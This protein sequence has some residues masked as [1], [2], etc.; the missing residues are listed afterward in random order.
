MALLPFVGKSGSGV[1]L[2][3]YAQP[4]A[5]CTEIAGIHDRRLKVR[6]ASPPRDGEANAELRRFLARLLGLGRS[7]VAIIAGERSRRKRV[8][9]RQLGGAIV[10][11][12][13]RRYL[14]GA[15][16]DD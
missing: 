14:T 16:C 11:R 7:S 15:E 8:V 5:S 1:T 4:G 6:L 9:I 10:D 2:E 12:A 13:L 3:V